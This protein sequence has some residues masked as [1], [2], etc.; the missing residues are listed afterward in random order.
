MSK[1]KE[2]YESGLSLAEVAHKLHMSPSGI[3][4]L[5]A[6]ESVIIRSR[7]DGVRIKHH[8]KLNSFS[9]RLPEI[10]PPNLYTLYI[11]GLSLYWGEGSKSGNTVAI[12]NSDPLLITAFLSFLRDICHV[13]EKRLRILIHYHSDQKEEEL[14]TFWSRVTKIKRAQFYV[15]TVHQRNFKESTKR[16]KFGTISLRY[17]DSLLLKDILQRIEKLGN[18]LKIKPE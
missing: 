1:A 5:L 18:E 14:I 4:Y 17:A 13:D 12:A 7:S 2:L 9:C 11:A 15:G 8:K 6:K 3:R 16:L 10:I